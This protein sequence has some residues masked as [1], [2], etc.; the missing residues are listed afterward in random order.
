[1]NMFIT[2]GN[3][4]PQQV[5]NVNPP[6]VVSAS[7]AVTQKSVPAPNSALT[8]PIIGRIHN[9]KAGCGSCGRK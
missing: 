3:Y 8:A 1:M 5:K 9:A 6:S 4:R 2:N 7:L